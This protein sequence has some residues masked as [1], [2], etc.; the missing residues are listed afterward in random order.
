MVIAKIPRFAHRAAPDPASDL[1]DQDC[2]AQLAPV[3]LLHAVM[4]G[5]MDGVMIVNEAGK[6]LQANRSAQQICRKLNRQSKAAQS[7][8]LPPEIWRICQAVLSS[9][10]LFPEHQIVPEDEI[11]LENSAVLRI[12]AQWIQSFS[13]ADAQPCLLV[14]LEDRAQSIQSLAA[15]DIHRYALTPCEGRVWQMR[16]EGCSYREIA[17]RLYISENTVKKH[18][19]SVLAK[20]RAVLRKEA[21]A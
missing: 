9:R 15:S 19:R 12:R 11:T 14:L 17:D 16:L 10:E 21:I 4:E 3:L 1:T 13:E 20:R 2:S 18:V 6:V 5:L 8:P 7:K